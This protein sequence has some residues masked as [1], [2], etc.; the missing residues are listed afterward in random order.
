MKVKA[1][2][3]EL[4]KNLPKPAFLKENRHVSKSTLQN[5][6]NT[7]SRLQPING[8]LVRSTDWVLSDRF[9]A[10][11]TNHQVFGLK[12]SINNRWRHRFARFD[13]NRGDFA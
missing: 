1:V 13:F 7:C 4:A 11:S 6:K 10:H 3:S 8:H 5:S 12:A 2:R 9:Q